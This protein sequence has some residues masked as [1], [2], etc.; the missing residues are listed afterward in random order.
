MNNNNEK[1]TNNL[2]YSDNTN[3]KNFFAVTFLSVNELKKLF[4][5]FSLNKCLFHY[6]MNTS[7]SNYFC[8]TLNGCNRSVSFY[9]NFFFLHKGKNRET[10]FYK[11]TNV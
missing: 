11:L 9:F 7:Q 3:G 8:I 10:K 6:Q 2:L 4:N 5:P 1:K